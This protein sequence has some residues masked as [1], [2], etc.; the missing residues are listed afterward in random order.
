MRD[1]E[2]IL[3]GRNPVR[4][5]LAS[6]RP[7]ERLF[8]QDGLKDGPILTILR[9]AKKADIPVERVTRQNSG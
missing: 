7:I 3:E 5:A 9:E 6:G 1:A 4:E 8:I 2:S